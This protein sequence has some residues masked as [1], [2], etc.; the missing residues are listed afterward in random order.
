MSTAP[1]TFTHAQRTPAHRFAPRAWQAKTY[2][3]GIGFIGVG[4]SRTHIGALR[5][6][7]R[8]AQR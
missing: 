3:K 7:R 8:A 5:I 2:R 4:F 6:A 1:H